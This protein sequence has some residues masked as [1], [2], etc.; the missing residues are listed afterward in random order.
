MTDS[1]MAVWMLKSFMLRQGEYFYIFI[2]HPDGGAIMVDRQ[3]YIDRVMRD[4]LITSP[5]L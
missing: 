2:S 5:R 4:F 1:I 3:R